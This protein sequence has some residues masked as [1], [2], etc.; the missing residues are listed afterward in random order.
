MIS[1]NPIENFNKKFDVVSLFIICDGKILL[2][3][4]QKNKSHEGTWG[5][6]AGKA[7]DGESLDEAVCRETFEETGIAVEES[8]LIRHETFYYV[9]HESLDFV[10][11]VFA[12]EL[13]KRPEVALRPVEHS[14]YSWFMPKEALGLDLVQDE[15]IPISD[16]FMTER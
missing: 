9:R 16:Y 4:R 12:L 2:L 7:D 13:D 1:I 5:P 8:K 10:F 15:E 14:E 3:K 6:P 11:H